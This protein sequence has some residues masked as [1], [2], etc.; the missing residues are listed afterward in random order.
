MPTR[1]FFPLQILPFNSSYL[2]I[3]II[4]IVSPDSTSDHIRDWLVVIIVMTPHSIYLSIYNIIDL[5]ISREESSTDVDI[6]HFLYPFTG[7]V[8]DGTAWQ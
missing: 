6:I 1:P 2:I 3:I 5:F 7:G 4:F 8:H